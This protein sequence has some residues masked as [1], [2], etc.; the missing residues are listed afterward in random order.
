[1]TF[2]PHF[3]RYPAQI[4]PLC[5]APIITPS[6]SRIFAMNEHPKRFERFELLE[7]LELRRRS[8]RSNRS[9]RSKRLRTR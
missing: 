1:M 6:Y 2:W 8:N 3:P 7:R 5:P 9:S 4:M